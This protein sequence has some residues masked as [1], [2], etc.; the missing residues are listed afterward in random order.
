MH[1]APLTL[2]CASTGTWWVLNRKEK[3]FASS[4]FAFDFLGDALDRFK[5]QVT[6]WGQDEHGLYLI[7]E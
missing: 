7:A 6:A 4:G 5:V 3:G 2:R 1:F